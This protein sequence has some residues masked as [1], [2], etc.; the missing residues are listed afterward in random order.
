MVTLLDLGWIGL[1]NGLELVPF[2]LAARTFLFF[3]GRGT[4]PGINRA[5]L[6]RDMPFVSPIGPLL[7]A[8]GVTFCLSDWTVEKTELRGGPCWVGWN[9]LERRR[10]WGWELAEEPG[11]ELIGWKDMWRDTS[12]GRFARIRV[13]YGVIASSV[14]DA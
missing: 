7:A 10:G 2:R 1:T 8:R 5:G 14:L 4:F 13:T 11:D 3:W 9:G 6:D 12:E